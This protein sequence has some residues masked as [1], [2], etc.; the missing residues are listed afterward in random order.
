MEISSARK[1]NVYDYGSQ[2]EPFR[3]TGESQGRCSDPKVQEWENLMWKF[4]SRFLMPSQ[5][6]SG[7]LIGESFQN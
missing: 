1:Q 7:M 2:R 5:E 6:R 4:Q 3:S